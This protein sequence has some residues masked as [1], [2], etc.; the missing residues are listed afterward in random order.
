MI[1]AATQ[2]HPF[3]H[4]CHSEDDTIRCTVAGDD[5]LEWPTLGDTEIKEFRT[6]GLALQVIPTLFPY[7]KADPT[8]PSQH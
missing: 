6:E 7:G 5:P 8:S 3:Y 2:V 4:K 1:T